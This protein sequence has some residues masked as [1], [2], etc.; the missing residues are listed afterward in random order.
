MSKQLKK[1]ESPIEIELLKT[2]YDEGFKPY[3]QV[4]SGPYRIDIGLYVKGKKVAVEC[5]GKVY[6]STRNQKNH[7]HRKNQYLLRNRWVVFRFT[8]SEINK[9][10]RECVKKIKNRF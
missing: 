1:C 5:D 9:N 3:A 7:D 2:L 6:H 4:K 8:G 10:S